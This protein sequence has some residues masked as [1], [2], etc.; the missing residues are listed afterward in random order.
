M[1][2]LK[3]AG[4]APHLRLV[5]QLCSYGYIQTDTPCLS[6]HLSRD[7]SFCLVV[8]DFAIKYKNIADLQ[9]LSNCL[10]ELYISHQGP[11]YLHSFPWFY[12]RL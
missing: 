5:A 7:V 4:L 6:R 3:E 8:D 9:H 11:S 1:C 2:G 12:Y 10:G